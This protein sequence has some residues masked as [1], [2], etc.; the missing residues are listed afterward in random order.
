MLGKVSDTSDIGFN[1]VW[2]IVA[3][4]EILDAQKPRLAELT[5]IERRVLKLVAEYKSNKE[6]ADELCISFRTVN[7]HRAN[8]CQKLEIHGKH[9]L[10]KFALDHEAELE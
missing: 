3:D 5:A 2:R 6:I 1:G 4:L 10:M 9:S 8:I 7:T